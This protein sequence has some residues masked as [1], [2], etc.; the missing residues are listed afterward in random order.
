MVDRSWRFE[1]KS[2]KDERQKVE[3]AAKETSVDDCTARKMQMCVS[4]WR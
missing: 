4:D 1:D 3:T 2:E